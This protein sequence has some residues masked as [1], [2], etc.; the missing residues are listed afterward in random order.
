MSVL[1]LARADLRHL[2]AYS[3]ARMEA[4]GGH[5]WLNANESP[6]PNAGVATALN[7]YPEPQPVALI[8]AL[9]AL[10]Q[11]SAD[12]IFVG[13]GSDEPIDLLTRAFCRAGQD[14]VIVSPPTFGMYT[15]AAQVQGAT[16]CAVPL[17]SA[18][19]YA[20]DFVGVRA[21]VNASTR[22]V[23]ACTPNNP[24]GNALPVAGLLDLALALRDR[25]VLVVD[26]AYA[27]YADAPSLIAALPRF[28]NL[29]VLRTLSKAHGLAAARIGVALA[30]PAVIDLLRRIMPPYPLPGPCVAAALQALSVSALAATRAHIQTIRSEREVL[31][32]ALV[33]RAEVRAVLPSQANFVTARFVDAEAVYAHWLAHGILVRSLRR[34]PGLEDA[35]R[36][37]VGSAQ[38]NQRLLAAL[39]AR[40]VAV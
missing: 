36:I 5:I 15:L 37:S 14:Q 33:Q 28:D 40:M 30:D 4:T 38:E 17:R 39:S 6:W 9:S 18:D 25:A 24:T 29:V 26:E 22:L 20:Y 19:A 7:R 34:Y 12:R 31:A 11:V 10:Y 23:Y 35:L 2:S 13:R 27:E 16:V 32:A 8:E 3:S 21:A 1:D